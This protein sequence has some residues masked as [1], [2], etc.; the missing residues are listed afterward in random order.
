MLVYRLL[1]NLEIPQNPHHLSFFH[2]LE[3]RCSVRLQA[4]SK[5]GNGEVPS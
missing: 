2:V 4:S 5:V 1:S 3:T